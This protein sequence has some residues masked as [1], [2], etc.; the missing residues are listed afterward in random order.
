MLNKL[1]RNVEGSL[2]KIGR[3]LGGLGLTPN[4]ITTLGVAAASLAGLLFYL[5]APVM[6]G[7]LILVSGLLDVLDGAV[8]KALKKTTRFG[9]VYDSVM[10]RYGEFVIL[11]GMA[12]G[13]YLDGVIAMI[14]IFSSVMVSYVRARVEAYTSKKFAVG[15]FER[16]ERLILLIL[17]S[18]ITPLFHRAIEYAVYVL[19]LGSQA[20]V[21]QRLYYAW[22]IFR[23]R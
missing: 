22:N 15:F 16:A 2:L 7:L 21:L 8:A 12:L 1:R 10:D 9:G 11:L 23:G 3:A 6:G 4:I 18:F 5:R 19:I 17:A 13:G 14:A 20:T